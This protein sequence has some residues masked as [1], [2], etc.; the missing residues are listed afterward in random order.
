MKEI[1]L[2]IIQDNQNITKD[3][4]SVEDAVNFLEGLAVPAD[5]K[6]NVTKEEIVD[7]NLEDVLADGDEIVIPNEE[8]H[9]VTIVE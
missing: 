2:T 7:N 6:H 1:K 5:I 8:E 9:I 3:F 4:T